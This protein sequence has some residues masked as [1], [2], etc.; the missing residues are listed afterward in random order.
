MTASYPFLGGVY[1]YRVGEFFTEVALRFKKNELNIAADA[2]AF[3]LVLSVFPLILFVLSFLGFLNLSYEREL[4]AFMDVLPEQIEIVLDSFVS[5]VGKNGS[6]GILSTSLVVVFI[7]AS[8]GFY[9]LVRG[10]K[11]AY[12]EDNSATFIKM[13]VLSF[14]LVIIFGACIVLT[15]YVF[16]FS[17]AVNSI[18]IDLK[19]IDHIPKFL[20]SFFMYLLNAFVMFA[21][22]VVLN[23][24]CVGRKLRIKRLIPGTLFTMGAWMII[25]KLF[26]IYISN[27]S[28]YNL[29][30]GSIGTLFI[31]ALWLNIFSYVLLLGGQINAVFC[32]NDFM[33]ELLTYH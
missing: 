20:N 30:Y 15:L 28:R 6:I 14:F 13:R 33:I 3:R 1:L 12:N 8:S 23:I 25:S 26:N 21:F 17:D 18:L 24:T 16:T 5:D 9:S 19:I 2:L 27:F 22:L 7:S 11:K 32:D 31:F 29:V 10:I 4:S